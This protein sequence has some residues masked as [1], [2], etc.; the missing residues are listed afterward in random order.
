MITITRIYGIISRVKLRIIIYFLFLF[1]PIFYSCI[2]NDIPYPFIH[3]NILQ[4][5]VEG[6]LGPAVIDSVSRTVTVN[7]SDTVDLEQVRVKHVELTENA[8]SSFPLDT[9]LDLSIPRQVTLTIYQDYLWTITAN[10]EIERKFTVTHQ[11][12]PTVWDVKG[13]RAIAYVSADTDLGEVAVKELQLGPSNATY[14][15][16]DIS[17]LKDFTKKKTVIVIYRNKMENWSLFVLPT[18]SDVSD[19]SVDAWANVAW[20]KSSGKA[21]AENGFELKESGTDIWTRVNPTFVQTDGGTFS[22]RVTGLKSKTAY[23]CRAYSG[24]TYSNVVSFTTEEEFSLPNAGFENWQK[25]D[26]IWLVYGTGE[27]MFWDTGN[28]GSATMNKNVTN[29][30]ETDVHGGSKSIELKSQF[31][32]LGGVVGKF[33][34]GNLFAGQ[35][36]KTDGTDGILSFGRPFTSRPTALKGYYK[37]ISVPINYTSLGNVPE[38]VPDE[39]II[40]IAIGDWD[41]PVEIRTKASERKLFDINDPHIIAYGELVQK[42]D[43]TS[44]TEFTIPLVYRAIDRKP[45]YLVI[46][47]SASRYGDYFTGGDGSTLT[48]D[49]FSLIYDYEENE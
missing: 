22:A 23:E 45:T 6:Q 1:L 10:Q 21:G 34:A 41:K 47:A 36:L 12:G 40:Y 33:A 29:Y 42:T 27:S 14:M 35:Y 13:C 17:Y 31:V 16:E 3:A 19:L 9:L 26:K 37:Y 46:V 48:L 25:K 7:L 30:I 15:P 43:I 39:G 4:F 28:H 5:E 18:E 38:G 32:G 2:K 11:I 8:V 49:D 44:W 24:E 20:L